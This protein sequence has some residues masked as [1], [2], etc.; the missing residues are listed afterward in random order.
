MSV[1]STPQYPRTDDSDLIQ[2]RRDA[3]RMLQGSDASVSVDAVD[4][5]LSDVKPQG[6]VPSQVALLQRPVAVFSFRVVVLFCLCFL[7]G[8]FTVGLGFSGPPMCLHRGCFACCAASFL[9][10]PCAI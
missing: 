4:R 10:C 1:M 8:S 6:T 3:G 5:V 7:L 2:V 9:V